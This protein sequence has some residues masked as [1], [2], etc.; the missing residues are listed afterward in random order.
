VFE[1]GELWTYRDLLVRVRRAA[2]AL[3][4]LGVQQG[5]YVLSWQPNGSHALLTW[6]ALNYLGAVYVPVNT[7]YRGT[8]LAHVIAN[9]GASLIILHGGLADRLANLPPGTLRRAIVVGQPNADLDIEVIDA[10]MLAQ[11]GP[12]PAPPAEPIAPWHIQSVIYTSGTTGP[13]K[14]VPSSYLHLWST[15]MAFHFVTESDRGMA[16]LPLFHAGGT[17][18]VYRM[19]V[20]GASVAVVD[21]FRTQTF[22]RTIRQTQ[23]TVLT[24]LGAMTPFL[25]KE[26]PS[27]QD[28][29]HTLRA[30][31]MVP[32]SDDSAAFAERFGVDVY[33]TFN[34][35]E[36][37]CP[38]FSR[39]NPTSPG[40]C[41]E[42]RPGVQ[43]RVVD[44]NDCEVPPGTVGE[45]IV[46]TDMPWAMNSGYLRNPEATAQAWRNG[47]FHTGDAF[48]MDSDGTFYFVDRMKDAIRRR[49]ENIS[50]FE[51][52]REIM[53]NDAVLEAAVVAAR[54]EFAE[55]EVM[56]VVAPVPGAS[57]NAAALIE[58]LRPRLPHFMLPRYIR[59]LSELPKTPTQKVQKHLLRDEGLTIDTWDSVA[60]G[61][62]FKRERLA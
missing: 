25:M 5:E 10:A 30:V 56:A 20:K 21:S 31:T 11:H 47:W 49:G 12:D 7:A 36:V 60:A 54:S 51:V 61:L 27:A 17:G 41:G 3:Q 50:S 45:L 38:I 24:L 8:L 52:E 32:L 13:S 4:A 35:T 14:G 2:A 9:S 6:F 40:S 34:M 42:P 29:D 39:R 28:R 59:F 62:Q 37:S 46:R 23:T 1:S 57:I 16:N 43:A 15:S 58:F 22:W 18:A 19:L 44:E 55:D 48:R 53:A 26:P 33:T